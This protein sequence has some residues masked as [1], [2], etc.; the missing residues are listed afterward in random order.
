[1]DPKSVNKEYQLQRMR[2]FL[3]DQRKDKERRALTEYARLM[4]RVL[5]RK[6]PRIFK[7]N[8]PLDPQM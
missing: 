1:M 6:H 8:Q 2:E 5:A 4:Q 7:D 3:D